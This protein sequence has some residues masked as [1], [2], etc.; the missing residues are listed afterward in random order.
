MSASQM[1]ARIKDLDRMFQAAAGPEQWVP[2][3]SRE[4]LDLVTKLD[5]E[6]NIIVPHAYVRAE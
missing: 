5:R 4:R 3:A 1:L 2:G 6:H